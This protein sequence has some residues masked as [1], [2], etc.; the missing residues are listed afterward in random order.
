MGI[1]EYYNDNKEGWQKIQEALLTE[2]DI[3]N[4]DED[5]QKALKKILTTELRH[6]KKPEEYIETY[7]IENRPGV[8]ALTLISFDNNQV[9][10]NEQNGKILF[11]NFFSPNC[12]TCRHE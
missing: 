11:L 10:L 7:R 5:Y 2:T 3:E 1:I 8:P 12:G 9:D 4:E 6:D